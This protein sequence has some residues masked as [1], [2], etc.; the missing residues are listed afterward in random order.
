MIRINLLAKK[1]SKKKASAIQHLLVGGA[2]VALAL[3]VMGWVWISQNGALAQVRREVA[4]AEAEKER[5]KNVNDEKTRYEKE[6]AEYERKLAIISKLQK[7]R[8]IPVRL[9][10]ELTKV[11]DVGTPI[12]LTSYS[13]NASGI[14]MDGYS[15][16]HEALRPFVEGLEGSPYYRGV[17]LLFS[18][19][20]KIGDRD[21]YRFS[22]KSGIEQPE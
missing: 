7:E 20:S 1:I 16:S 17:E 10:D 11:I 21:V 15:L 4:I 19:R 3:A 22:V 14:S 6:Q 8:L 5:L 13:F 2:A 18:E 9:L 12:W